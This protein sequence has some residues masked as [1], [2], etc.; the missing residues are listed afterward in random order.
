M[1]VPAAITDLSTTPSVNSPA[2]SEQQN[3][4]DDYLRT[5]AAFIRQLYDTQVAQQNVSTVDSILIAK[6]A[7]DA[8][9]LTGAFDY[10]AEFVVDSTSRVLR[11]DRQAADGYAL[12]LTRGGTLAGYIALSANAMK[13]NGGSS[14]LTLQ[15]SATAGA[16]GTDALTIDAAQNVLAV[17]GAMGYG[18]GAG[19]AV[20]QLTSKATGVTLNKPTGQITMNAASLAASTAVTFT[21][22]D[23]FIG[24]NDVIN[25]SIK[26]GGTAGAYAVGVASV[27]A[28]SAVLYLRNLTAGALAEAVVLQFAI[29]KGAVA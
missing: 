16:V 4:V 23:S 13:I 9:A 11:V 28:G 7:S 10:G 6:A 12:I 27:A 21:L 14:G 22:T 2:G 15:T 25:V 1:P 20:T 19:G 24:A 3:L 8:L 5:F 26:S 18:A 17:G 29:T